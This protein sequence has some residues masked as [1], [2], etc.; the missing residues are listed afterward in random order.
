MIYHTI[1]RTSKGGK[2]LALLKEELD[3]KYLTPKLKVKVI[4]TTLQ[5]NNKM[6]SPS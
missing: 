2:H 5:L 1:L 4:L 3:F 6:Y